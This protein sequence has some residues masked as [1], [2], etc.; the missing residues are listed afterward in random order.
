MGAVPALF[1]RTHS[2]PPPTLA[3]LDCTDPP[4]ESFKVPE[5]I[6]LPQVQ[7]L[8]PPWFIASRLDLVF[9]TSDQRQAYRARLLPAIVVLLAQ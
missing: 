8:V 6:I 3:H 2:Y 1:F 9:V 5:V 7:W 4:G